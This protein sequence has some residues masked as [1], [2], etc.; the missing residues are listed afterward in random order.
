MRIVHFDQMFHPEFGDQI[1]VL[2]KYQVKQGHEVYIVT[3]SSDV[4]HPR[5]ENF[6]DNS[7]MDKKDRLFEENTG[8]KIVR[9]EVVRYIS[10]R[11]IYKN[12]YVKLINKLAPDILF[13]HFNDT[14]VGMH[15]TWLSSKLKYPVVFDSHMLNMASKN[16][17]NKLFRRFY[18]MI[19]TPII[20]KN[21]L[22]V[23]RTQDDNYVNKELGIPQEQTPF[24]SFG[25][26]TNMF[27]PDLN[28]REEIRKKNNI[29][30][31]DFVIMYAGQMNSSKGV[32]L[33]A[34]AF[35]NCYKAEKR[36]LLVLIGN[37][38]NDYE[39]KIA[40]ILKPSNSRVIKFPIQKYINLPEFYQMADVCVFPKQCSLSFYDVQACGLPVIAEDNNINIERLSHDNG[41]V[42]KT[43]SIKSLEDKILKI[44]RVGNNEYKLLSENSRRFVIESYDYYDIAN[45]Y[46]EI[47][48]QEVK[49]Y[50][51]VN[52]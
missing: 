7:E 15:Y 23:I 10:G 12:G 27:F 11:A 22:I 48:Y 31:D 5:F 39:N 30:K 4:L 20:K 16:K 40:E 32:E 47:L 2:P 21:E 33:L 49:R 6:A 18:K 9:I 25:S 1:N 38:T 46:T 8:V 42:Y 13:C 50:K 37:G 52:K 35:N 36:L 28:V 34:E 51:K 17:F 19:L 26:D 29:K 14:V 3:G 43:N 44:A 24:I 45:Q 41:F